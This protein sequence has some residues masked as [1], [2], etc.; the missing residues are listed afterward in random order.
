M[1]LSITGRHY[2]IKEPLKEY[3]NQKMAKIE[4]YFHSP[5]EAHLVINM[6]KSTYLV[7]ITF[8]VNRTHFYS[9][10]KDEHLH[11]AIDKLIDKL[12][13]QIKK[14]KEKIKH[15]KNKELNRKIVLS[16]S[17]AKPLYKIV[18]VDKFIRE[19]LSVEE[20][21][22]ELQSGGGDFLAFF[23]RETER[24]NVIHRQDELTYEL[25]EVF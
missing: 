11:L 8:S 13:V 17:E 14:H 4:K 5:I 12:E 19:P 3:L 15:H 1:Y 18:E 24:I 21:V 22:R 6:V 10:T 23:N 20:A 25:T 7:E 16:S 2:K 9:K